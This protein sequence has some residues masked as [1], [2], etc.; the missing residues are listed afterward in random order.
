ME[1]YA[2]V[3]EL[4]IWTS[5]TVESA[6]WN[7]ERW[8]V[9]VRQT[10]CDD[11]EQVHTLYPRHI[12]QATGQAGEANMPAIEGTGSFEGLIRHSSDF[13]GA[14]LLPPNQDRP[15]HAIVIGSSNSAHDIAQDFYEN[16]YQ[17]TMIQRSTTCVDPTSYI[18][19]KNL[20]REDGPPLDIA[21]LLTNSLPSALMKRNQIDV[22]TR[23]ESQYRDYFQHLEAAGLRLDQGPDGAGRKLKYLERG[24]GY[25]IDMGASRLI[26]EGHIKVRS[27]VSV[28]RI[29]S[30]SVILTDGT[31][32][33]ADE[34]IFATGYKSMKTTTRKIFGDKVADKVKE[35]WGL[36]EDG[37]L[38]SVWRRSGH[39]G[40]W[41]AAGNLALTR[42]YS[43]LLALQIKGVEEG[44]MKY[45]D[46]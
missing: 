37:E 46:W 30:Q 19:G 8:T 38:K 42:Y 20:Y 4:N 28:S 5:T 22:T 9:T 40:F 15:H 13:H 25:Y 33:P 18:G 2:R 39:P 35:V 43:K 24:G 26:I 10:F 44:L 17:V 36:D 12:I 11:T 3:M 14:K 21:D 45:D 6:S 29:C 16:G 41:F 7:G 31:S 34:I 1:T 32:L 27:G 23:I